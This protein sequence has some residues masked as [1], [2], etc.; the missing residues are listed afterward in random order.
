M[1]RYPRESQERVF[2]A[3]EG[4]FRFFAGVCHRGIYDNMK[5]AVNTVF[6][7]KEREYNER[8]V[9][10]CSHQ[11]V[12]PLACTPGLRGGRRDRWRTRWG[13]RAGGCSCRGLGGRS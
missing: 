2:E 5:P 7:V 11:L 8:F 3:H 10:M 6:I 9:P 13:R 4:A 12:E 1:Q